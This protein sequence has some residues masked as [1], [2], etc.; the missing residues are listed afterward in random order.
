MLAAQ[1]AHNCIMFIVRFSSTL[2]CSCLLVSFALLPRMYQMLC[3]S[4][5]VCDLALVRRWLLA[6]ALACCSDMSLC[7]WD[8][9]AE[10]ALVRNYD[11]HTEFVLGCDFNNFIE[12]QIASTSWDQYIYVW[13]IS[14]KSAPK[15]SSGGSAGTAGIGLPQLDRKESTP[16]QT[17]AQSQSTTVA[18]GAVAPAAVG[19]TLS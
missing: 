10:D 15:L 1:L 4:T 7:I 13:N 6:L 12:N 2:L 19:E 17:S 18:G 16:P 5:A 3:S 11:Q 8:T 14:A 9:E